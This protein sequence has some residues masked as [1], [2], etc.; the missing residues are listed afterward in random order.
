MK[1]R[2]LWITDEIERL[3]TELPSPS[4]QIQRER[5]SHFREMMEIEPGLIIPHLP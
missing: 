5:Y 4:Q 3:A 1:A 2:S